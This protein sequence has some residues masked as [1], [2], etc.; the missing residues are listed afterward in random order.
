MAV[1]LVL[2]RLYTS[3][4]EP[5]GRRDKQRSRHG[6][7]FCDERP[8]GDITELLRRAGTL[9]TRCCHHAA[10][11]YARTCQAKIANNMPLSART[12]SRCPHRQH[13]WIQYQTRTAGSYATAAEE[14]I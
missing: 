5:S 4:F 2:G 9:S 14:R 7:H 13:A 1:S 10:T 6:R 11:V 8:R 3:D 12:T